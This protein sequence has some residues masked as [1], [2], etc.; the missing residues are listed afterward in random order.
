MNA[1]GKIVYSRDPAVVVE[2]ILDAAEAEFMAAG[3]A[4]AS[5]NRILDRFGGSKA[6]L[7]RHFP[8][9]A[10]MFLAVIRRIGERMIAEVDWAALETD[11][12]RAWLAAFARMALKGI[13]RDDA[14]FVG[15]M[16][17]AQGRNFP[18]IRETFM[19]VA[20]TPMLAML[21]GRFRD[22]TD[23]GLLACVDAEADAVTF[24]DMALGG[25]INRALFGLEQ[26][27]DDAFLDRHSARA[28]ALFLDGRRTR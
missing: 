26:P 2:R 12:P 3:F 18:M 24:F 19:A 6:T 20:V 27:V 8:T 15:R 22:W 11:D 14:L 9:K 7:F 13:L 4:G 17:V 10:E 23:Q 21:A 25:W 1:A 5:T 16:V 28:A